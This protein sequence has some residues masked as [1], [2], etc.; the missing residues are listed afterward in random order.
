MPPLGCIRKYT[1]FNSEFN[2]LTKV[3]Q[4]DSTSLTERIIQLK[5]KALSIG[6]LV[7]ACS[8]SL[9]PLAEAHSANRIGKQSWT[10]QIHAKEQDRPLWPKVQ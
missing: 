6:A 2:K 9:A 3:L 5:N 7:C 8:L 10:C 4:L 1:I